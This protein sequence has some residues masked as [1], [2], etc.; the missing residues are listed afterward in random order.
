L[1]GRM[2]QKTGIDHLFFIGT[3]L[4][5]NLYFE[6]QN[7]FPFLQHSVSLYQ[8]HCVWPWTLW[9]FVVILIPSIGALVFAHVLRAHH[10]RILP[11][12]LMELVLCFFFFVAPLLPSSYF[13]FHHWYAGWLIGMHANF[14]VWWSRFAMA[15][16]WGMYMNGIAVSDV[17]N[18][19]EVRINDVSLTICLHSSKGVRKGSCFNLRVCLLF[20]DR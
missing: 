20:D 3:A 11:M 6:A 18:A 4:L 12:K 17:T 7:F 1:V 5:S 8:M 9:M 10:E 19:S 15:W 2:W 16:C 13:H 14:D